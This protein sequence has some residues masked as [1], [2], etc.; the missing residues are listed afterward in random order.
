MADTGGAAVHTGESIRTFRRTCAAIEYSR[1]GRRRRRQ[2]RLLLG[3]GEQVLLDRFHTR[4]YSTQTPWRSLRTVASWTRMPKRRI[5]W[6]RIPASSQVQRTRTSL[7]TGA[8]PSVMVLDTNLS[9][10]LISNVWPKSGIIPPLRSAGR[11]Q[12]YD[13]PFRIALPHIVIR[14]LDGFKTGGRSDSVRIAARQANRWILAYLQGQKRS[15]STF[16][17]KDAIEMVMRV[18][19]AADAGPTDV[20]TAAEATARQ[21]EER[22]KEDSAGG[23]GTNDEQ[24]V[25]LCVSLAAST[26]SPDWLLSSGGDKNRAV[27]GGEEEDDSSNGSGC[28]DG[29]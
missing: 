29:I 12:T 16:L 24:T 2:T 13:L 20:A 17:S 26:S 25:D 23:G 15:V 7:Y 19:I 3:A 14:E 21:H 5:R 4:A 10:L 28:G 18:A 6:L 1:Y 8:G 27:G 9:A 11:V 22:K